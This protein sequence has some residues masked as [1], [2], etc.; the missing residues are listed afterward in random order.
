MTIRYAVTFEFPTR[1]PVTHRGTIAA[2]QVATCA[3]RAIR[4]A[5]RALR[6]VAW[7]SVVFVALERLDEPEAATTPSAQA[8]LRPGGAHQAQ[9]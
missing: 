7:S 3:S 5:R 2:S 1:P 6:P 4:I 8:A 9:P